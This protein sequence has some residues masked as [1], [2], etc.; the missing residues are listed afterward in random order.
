MEVKIL[1]D[2][3]ERTLDEARELWEALNQ[4]FVADIPA[5]AGIWTVPVYVP[6]PP[7]TVPSWGG[8]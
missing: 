3:Q 1:I 7:Y 4:I 8:V 2:G 6:P 5:G